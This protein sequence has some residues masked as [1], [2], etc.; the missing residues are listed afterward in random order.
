MVAAATKAQ[1]VATHNQVFSEPLEAAAQVRL[2][3]AL[4]AQTITLVLEIWVT[5]ETVPLISV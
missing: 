5:V 1:Q 2:A 4:L 3:E